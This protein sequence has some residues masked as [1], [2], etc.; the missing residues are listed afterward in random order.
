[1]PD[2]VTEAVVM[3]IVSASFV[4][5]ARM[6]RAGLEELV[7]SGVSSSQ[8]DSLA[9]EDMGG[10]PMTDVTSFDACT[11]DASSMRIR[12]NAMPL[13]VEGWSVLEGGSLGTFSRRQI[14][15]CRRPTTPTLRDR[16]VTSPQ[17]NGRIPCLST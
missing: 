16:G 17:K 2:P 7:P 12:T 10:I 11:N 14:E 8:M 1:M 13:V 15:N 5:I 3:N 6:S 4:G 9:V